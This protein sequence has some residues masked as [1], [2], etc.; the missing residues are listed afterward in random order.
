MFSVKYL[1]FVSYE[2]CSVSCPDYV[3]LSIYFEIVIFFISAK[4]KKEF[5]G[6]GLFNIARLNFKN[7]QLLVLRSTN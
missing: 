2:L 4:K 7:Q 5:L 1:N 6:K 3:I